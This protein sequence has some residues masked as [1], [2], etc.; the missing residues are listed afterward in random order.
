MPFSG[1]DN[2]TTGDMT[3]VS[4][5][6]SSTDGS[7]DIY[8]EDTSKT[9]ILEVKLKEGSSG[10][11]SII[12]QDQTSNSSAY[13]TRRLDGTQMSS[14]T[15]IPASINLPNGV[16]LSGVVSSSTTNGNPP[17]GL[18]RVLVRSGG[19]TKPYNFTGDTTNSDG[20]YNIYLP[21]ASYSQ[22]IAF[23]PDP[24]VS[25]TINAKVANLSVGTSDV[26]QNFSVALP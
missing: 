5:E 14:A 2:S 22:V 21:A 7:V 19:T 24:A 13:A 10:A 18:M 12:Y 1:V 6:V 16:K 9:Y 25:N 3:L 23:N 26:T 4:Q 20:T 8:I 11:G 15:D 17:L